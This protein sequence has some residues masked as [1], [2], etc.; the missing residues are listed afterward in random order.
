MII[1]EADATQ[2]QITFVVAEINR[3]G[4]RADVSKGEYKTIIG[5]IG[6]EKI[7]PFSYFEALLGVKET[8]QVEVPYKLISREYNE[9]VRET[10]KPMVI[11]V[12]DVAIGGNGPIFMAGPCAIESKD[13][14]FRI[15]ESVKEADAHILRGGIFKPRTSVHSFHGL[16]A[17]RM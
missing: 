17:E 2:E 6:D 1:M 15:V 14:L 7:V 9:V 12:G 8:I 16:V 5:L 11:E 4:L 10:R 13:Q 3:L